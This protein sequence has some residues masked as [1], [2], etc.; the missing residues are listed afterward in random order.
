MFQHCS[1]VWA[2]F[3]DSFYYADD[4]DAPSTRELTFTPG[5]ERERCVNV[6]FGDDNFV[7]PDEVFVVTFHSPRVPFDSV[8]QNTT[9]V[10]IIDDEGTHA[11][12]MSMHSIV[13]AVS[14]WDTVN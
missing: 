13:T 14:K 5:S 7:E 8:S 1:N 11:H 9:T 3:T 10:T 6:S 4:I 12:S 2:W